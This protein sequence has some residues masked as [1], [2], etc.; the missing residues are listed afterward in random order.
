MTELIDPFD[1]VELIAKQ[2]RL[3]LRLRR[4]GHDYYEISRALTK[5]SGREVPIKLVRYRIRE[6]WKQV[7]REAC[8]EHLQWELDRL[9]DLQRRVSRILKDEVDEELTLKA[10]DRALK[11]ADRRAKLLGLD[12][13]QRVDAT[14]TETTQQDLELQEMVREA[15]ARTARQEQQ[16]RGGRP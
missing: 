16:L 14:V 3:A 15:K 6:H 1:D 11:I 5:F 4:E 8:E 7:E 12:A 9:D 10:I 13:P 2:T